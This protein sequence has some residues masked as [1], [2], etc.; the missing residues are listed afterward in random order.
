M[1][2]QTYFYSFMSTAQGAVGGNRMAGVGRDL[3]C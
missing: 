3:S 1:L 2:E